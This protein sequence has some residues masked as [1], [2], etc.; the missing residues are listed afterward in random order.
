MK[1]MLSHGNGGAENQELIKEIFFKNF[2]ND[3]LKAGEDSAIIGNLAFSSDSF[4][5]EPIFFNGGD[6]GKLSICGTCNDLAM[7]GAKPKY[8]TF[9]VVIE[10][11]FEIE[12]LKKI[13]QSIAKELEVNGA[14]IVAG[15]TKVVPKGKVDK[16][17][18][19][20]SGIGEIIKSG[21]SA[22]NLKIGDVILL[23]KSIGEHGA[24]IFAQREGIELES[25]LQSDCQ[26]LWKI[27]KELIDSNIEIRAM[28]D[29]TRG[30]IASLFNEWS[31]SSLVGIELVEE[32]I[33]IKDEVRGICELL[34]FEAFNLA[35]E[36]TF[37]LATTKEDSIKALEILKSF[38]NSASIVGKVVEGNRVV[39]C[40][41]WGSKRILDMPS[42]ELLPR[43][44]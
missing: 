1:V 26:S 5:I 9:S 14:L 20:I 32:S 40:S 25:E 7:V 30:G 36:G 22:K 2:S 16:I 17:F 12:E 8:L 42:G 11:G 23:S 31:Q 21:I 38:D 41:G 44:C 24:S 15:D 19:N 35:N 43:I 29:A 27:V 13:T 37:A 6:I 33:N 10:E 34:G 18:I 28:R 3:I 4:T 39:L